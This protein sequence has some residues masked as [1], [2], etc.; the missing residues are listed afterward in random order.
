[1][2]A[3]FKLSEVCFLM[4]LSC[5]VCGCAASQSPRAAPARFAD[6]MDADSLRTAVRYSLDY[7][8]K[9]PPDR[10]VGEQPRRFTAREII[11]SL[12]AFEQ[13]LDNWSCAEC[14]SREI[15]DRFDFVPSSSDQETSQVLF[16]GYYQPVIDGSLVPTEK[17][18]YPLYARPAD[19]IIAEQVTLKSPV[20]VEKIA[21]RAEGEQFLPYY[22]RREIDEGGLLRGRGLEIA[23]VADP[24]ELFF[25]HIQGSGIIR[26]PDGTQLSVGYAA[27]N[28]HPYRSIGRLLIDN[29]KVARE[30]MSMQR[31]RR[32]LNDHPQEQSEILAYNESY[33]FFRVNNGG[34]LGS[35][36][37]PIT[38]GRSIATDSR[39]FPKGALALVQTEIPIIDGAG[40]LTG[41]RS[42]TRIVINQDTGGAIRGLQRAD[43]YFG[44]GH[45]AEDLAGYMNRQGKMFFLIPKDAGVGAASASSANGGEGTKNAAQPSR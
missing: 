7:L 16:T 17:F 43:I 8:Q 36:E 21:G 15:H 3:R 14:A 4:L 31:L 24:V 35:L 2:L 44:T 29:G 22:T 13:V 19:L 38:A 41:W 45:P 26:L 23:W 11:A 12:K 6:D 5:V 40:Q 1:M 34:P 30:D 32:Y 18:R 20:S 33:V 28:G 39:L 10:V 42:L 27:Q 37:V 9:L 25:L